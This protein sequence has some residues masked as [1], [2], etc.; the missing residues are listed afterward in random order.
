M[1]QTVSMSFGPRITSG[2]ITLRP[3][4]DADRVG[5]QSLGVNAEISRM[6]GGAEPADREMTTNEAMQWFEALG[7]EGTVEWIVEHDGTF[8]GTTR[9]HSFQQGPERARFAIGLL[10]TSKLG[11][12]IGSAVT[13]V[14]LRY[15]FDELELDEIELIVLDFNERAQR[16]YRS[17][18]FREVA[19]IPS[20]VFDADRRA[21]DIVMVVTAAEFSG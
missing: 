5:R 17:C 6:F 8:L 21:D 4:I 11:R 12:G 1:K 19:R 2:N 9:L 20:D 10:A 16:C 3:T 18:G 13:R 14:V 15:G 7:K